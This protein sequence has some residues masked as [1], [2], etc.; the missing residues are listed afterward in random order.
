MKFLTY[1]AAL[2]ATA[3]LASAAP[4]VCVPGTETLLKSRDVGGKQY[5]I[6]SCTTAEGAAPPD[7]EQGNPLGGIT[8]KKRDQDLCGAPCTTYCNRGTGGPNPN[9]CSALASEYQ[10]DG[11]FDLPAG[12][13]WYWN[14]GS[15]EVWQ[16]NTS[17]GNEWYCYDESNWGGV[18]NYLAWNCQATTGGYNGGSCH[19]YDNTGVGWVQVQTY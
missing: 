2:I 6:H 11:Q 1:A 16:V 4:S 12:Q 7:G 3:V 5:T 17:S 8:F 10:N 15:C 9:D 19:F 13:T 14:Y 18:V